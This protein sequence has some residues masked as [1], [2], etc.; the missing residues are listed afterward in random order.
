MLP[1]STKLTIT[2]RLNLLNRQNDHT[3]YD[4]G[5]PSPGLGQIQKCEG[6]NWLMS[7][8]VVLSKPHHWLELN[9][10]RLLVLGTDYIDR[11]IS[12]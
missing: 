5:C 11:Y 7:H 4:V 12:T 2:T 9:S 10:H 8:K 6:L 3:T 1:I